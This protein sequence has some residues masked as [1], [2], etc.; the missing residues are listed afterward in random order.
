MGCSM[1]S[2]LELPEASKPTPLFNDNRGAIDWSHGLNISKR[3]RHFNIREVAVRDD[4]R[5]K[6]VTVS[7]LPGNVNTADLFTKEIRA[8]DHFQTLAFRLVSPMDLGGCHEKSIRQT[9]CEGQT[10]PLSNQ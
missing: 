2:D 10:D 9:D 1:A 5:D 4:I 8:N 6:R 3:L 7:H